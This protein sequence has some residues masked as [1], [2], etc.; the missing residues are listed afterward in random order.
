MNILLRKPAGIFLFLLVFGKVLAQ[1]H[2]DVLIHVRDTSQN[3]FTDTMHKWHAIPTHLYRVNDWVSG[4]I[5]LVA[6]AADLYAI[7]YV[8]KSKKEISEAEIQSLNQGIFTGFDRIAFQQNP[9]TRASFAKASD[10]TLPGLIVLPGLLAFDGKIR[11]DWFRILLMYYEMHSITFSI[12]NYSVFGPAFQNKFRPLVYYNNLT[13]EERKGGNNRNSMYS[14]HTATA[15]A[16]TFFLVKVY[17]DYHPEIGRKK[18]LFYVIAAIPPAIEGYFRVKAML[19][20]PSDVMIG[21][22]VGA[23][24]G[25][26]V[27]EIHRFK[28]HKVTLGVTGT[29]V[30]PG[31][32][33]N[34][35]I[36]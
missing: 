17:S 27:P 10:Y 13:Y 7:P 29:P 28:N 6:T 34:W 35:N 23:A 15:I 31:L 1:E 3:S 25:L 9:S 16:S 8:I 14:G 21:M 4:S 12:Y 5:C 30:G 24:C 11:Q 18:Y 33:F 20:F 22:S 26:L 32:G 19:H 2:D 36:D